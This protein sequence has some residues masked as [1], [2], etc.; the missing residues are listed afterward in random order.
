MLSLQAGRPV[1]RGAS[2][3]HRS[4]CE[5]LYCPVKPGNEKL[6][7]YSRARLRRCPLAEIG[8]GARQV[9]RPDRATLELAGPVCLEQSGSTRPTISVDQVKTMAWPSL[10]RSSAEF[11]N[12]FFV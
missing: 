4:G 5:R 1:T 6:R 2:S 7:F 12:Y 9:E 3:S 10:V 8:D 11:A